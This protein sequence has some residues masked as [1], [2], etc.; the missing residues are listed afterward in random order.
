MFLLCPH[1]INS[2]SEYPRTGL[3]PSNVMLQESQVYS[4]INYLEGSA[5]KLGV[6]VIE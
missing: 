2:E 4:I 3:S 1:K 6:P 5:Y